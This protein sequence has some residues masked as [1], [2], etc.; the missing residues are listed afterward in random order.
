MLVPTQSCLKKELGIKLEYA[1]WLVP[2][3][4]SKHSWNLQILRLRAHSSTSM[5]MPKANISKNKR[6]QPARQPFS[7]LIPWHL[8]PPP[9]RPPP[10]PS[11][12]NDHYSTPSP[13]FNLSRVR[14]TP[15]THTFVARASR[16]RRDLGKATC[17]IQPMGF[18]SRGQRRDCQSSYVHPLNWRVPIGP[19]AGGL[20]YSC[21]R[22]T[23][24]N[25][26]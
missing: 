25:F 22:A 18:A 20:S 9:L 15:H 3:T 12:P 5:S 24:V 7:N 11:R 2:N 26:Y 17:A 13:P 23:C 1:L 21:M 6:F 14:P 19:A 16:Q 8:N 4:S 10:L